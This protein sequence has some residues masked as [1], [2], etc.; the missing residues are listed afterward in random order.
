MARSEAAMVIELAH[1]EIAPGQEEQFKQAYASVEH[2][3]AAA[4]GHISHALHQGIESPSQFV[5]I[6][7]WATLADH[8]DGFRRSEAYA[9]FRAVIG[10]FRAAPVEV[11]H[12]HPV[13]GD[14]VQPTADPGAGLE[15]T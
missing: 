14:L 4:K 13:A 12:L 2:L 15:P 11:M 5:A 7:H 8:V 6:V 3:L 9:Q 1:L 10:P